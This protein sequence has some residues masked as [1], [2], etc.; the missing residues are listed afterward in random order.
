MTG[1]G[2]VR[3]T[4]LKFIDQCFAQGAVND[5]PINNSGANRCANC[6]NSPSTVSNRDDSL[7]SCELV[8]RYSDYS[9]IEGCVNCDPVTTY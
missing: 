1:R 4:I 8:N 5:Q 9:I 6:V 3:L 2:V 7:G